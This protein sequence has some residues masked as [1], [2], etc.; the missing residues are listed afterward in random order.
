MVWTSLRCAGKPAYL[1]ENQFENQK[2]VR[3]LT[4]SRSELLPAPFL[5]FLNCYLP[6]NPPRLMH[7]LT[8]YNGFFFCPE[9]SVYAASGLFLYLFSTRIFHILSLSLSGT[10]YQKRKTSGQSGY[11]IAHGSEERYGIDVKGF[12]LKH[13]HGLILCRDKTFRTLDVKRKKVLI[14]G[15]DEINIVYDSGVYDGLIRFI[16]IAIRYTAVLS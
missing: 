14:A 3:T 5:D 16:A 2:G 8:R 12:Y 7:L 11:R 10:P 13:I 15:Y 9:V 4:V 1:F 6:S